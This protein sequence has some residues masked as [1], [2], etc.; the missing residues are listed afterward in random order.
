MTALVPSAPPRQPLIFSTNHRPRIPSRP[1][2]GGI[3]RTKLWKHVSTYVSIE[4]TADFHLHTSS[5]SLASRR[6]KRP[7]SC[8]LDAVTS[9]WVRRRNKHEH[10]HSSLRTRLIYLYLC[11][12]LGVYLFFSLLPIIWYMLRSLCCLLTF[13]CC[14]TLVSF[15]TH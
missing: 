7:P 14:V 6:W 10:S 1:H 11:C 15:I 12:I 3:I 13:I 4:L 5:V 9:T 8:C 2:R